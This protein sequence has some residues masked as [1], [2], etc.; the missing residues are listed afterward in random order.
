MVDPRDYLY[1]GADAGDDALG[2][3]FAANDTRAQS[4]Q[5]LFSQVETLKDEFDDFRETRD[6]DESRFEDAVVVDACP[7]GLRPCDEA[8]M[9][10][11]GFQCPSLDQAPDPIVVDQNG[12]V[13]YM[14]SA[15]QEALGGPDAPKNIASLAHVQ[16]LKLLDTLKELMTTD[17]SRATE[18]V[19][20]VKG[21]ILQA[22]FKQ[23]EGGGGF[24]RTLGFGS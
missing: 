2:D 16:A 24:F 10:A 17:P 20:A 15:M 22:K 14:S 1:G 13:C 7:V 6:S 23:P 4:L 5:K 18:I 11:L 12:N 3:F 21:T 8:K 19:N 9:N